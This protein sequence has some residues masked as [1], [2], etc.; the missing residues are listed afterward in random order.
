MKGQ[1]ERSQPWVGSPKLWISVASSPGGASVW[2]GL[3]WIGRSEEGGN[4]KWEGSESRNKEG[5][6]AWVYALLDNSNND[7]SVT[8]CMPSPAPVMGNVGLIFSRA[9]RVKY[10][11]SQ[12]GRK[13]NSLQEIKQ[14]AGLTGS[15]WWG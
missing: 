12:F 9:P 7:I 10:C 11:L 8:C 3:Q 5:K 4:P 13:E 15:E 6:E 2:G 1:G 14:Q